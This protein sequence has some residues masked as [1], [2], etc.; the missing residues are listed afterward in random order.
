MKINITFCYLLTLSISVY[1]Q[2][3]DQLKYTFN[4]KNVVASAIDGNWKAVKLDHEISFQKDTTV[5]SII[6]K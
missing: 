2:D 4:E 3:A 6:P 1:G 5:L